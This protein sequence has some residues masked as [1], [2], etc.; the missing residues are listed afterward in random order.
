MTIQE[1]T[2]PMKLSSKATLNSGEVALVGSGPGDAELLTLRALRFIEQAEVTVYDRLV[3][4]EI[5]ALLPE[6]SENFYVGKEQAKHCVPQD[7]INQLLVD[8]AKL[9]KKVLRLK[10]GDPFIFGR[11]GE[12]AEYLLEN[13]VSCHICPGITAASGCTTYAGIPLTHRGVAQGCTFITGHIQNNGQ[14]N[15]PWESL[16]SDSQTVV[17]YMG[18]NTLPKITEQLI[19]HGRNADTPAALIRRGTQPEQQVFRGK[20]SNL[21]ELVEKHKITPPTLIV[22][23]EVVNQLTEQ[24][25]STPGFLKAEESMQ[26]KL[27]NAQ[28]VEKV[29]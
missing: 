10:G 20:L 2:K 8:Q 3:S 19:K 26:F 21:P 5:L 12:E 25:L 13:G 6:G 16:S 18:I 22:I 1:L 24:Q 29:S 28:A 4:D 9:G 17:F 11:G 14:L 23:G 27:A 7:K 15:L